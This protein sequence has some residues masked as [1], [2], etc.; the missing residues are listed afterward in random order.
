MASQVVQMDYPVVMSASQKFAQASEVLVG[1]GR[2]LEVTITMLR[3]SAFLGALVAAAFAQYLETI[4]GKVEQLAN[5]TREFSRD[6]ARAVNDH[7]RGQ[8]QAGR[9]FGE[10]VR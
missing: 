2:A 7:Q 4:K 10:G 5:V 9:Y 1:I 6:L 3:T 8:Y